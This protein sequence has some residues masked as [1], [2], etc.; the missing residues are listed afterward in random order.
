MRLRE[1]APGAGDGRNEPN[2]EEVLRKLAAQWWHGDEDPR[3]E[4]ALSALGWTI[5]Q[6]ESDD[7]DGVFVVRIGDINGDSYISFPESELD[8]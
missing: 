6:N 1:F 5:G 7:E 8:L 4:R 2:E 3:A